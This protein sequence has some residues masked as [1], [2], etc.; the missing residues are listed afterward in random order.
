MTLEVT[1][2]TGGYADLTVVRDVS[3]A[4]RAGEVLAVLGSNGAGK[5]TL[6]R[7]VSGV[8]PTCV[9]EV[10]VMGARVDTKPPYRRVSQGLAFVQEGKRVFRGRTVRE[11][12]VLGAYGLRGAARREIPQRLDEAYARFPVLGQMQGRTA[13]ALSGGQQ[14]M[15]SIAQALMRRPQVLLLDEPSAGLAP[16]IVG[17]VFEVIAGLRDEGMTV[18]LVEQAKGWALSVAQRIAVLDLGRIIY[19]GEPTGAEASNA[20]ERLHLG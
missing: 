7:G 9:G 15:L 5:T 6:L 12:L 4:A 13:G 1:G 20:L 18:V 19:L 11:N 16:A 17:D 2:L 3:L 14:Q 10:R 8:L